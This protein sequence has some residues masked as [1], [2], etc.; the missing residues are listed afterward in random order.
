MHA[1]S[2]FRIGSFSCGL[3]SFVVPLELG[4]FRIILVVWG[5]FW[6]GGVWPGVEAN[7]QH[8][9][10][11]TGVSETSLPNT[12]QPTEIYQNSDVDMNR[13]KLL[14][15]FYVLLSSQDDTHKRLSK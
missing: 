9:H 1:P 5:V 7:I 2:P 12:W 14:H 15:R 11:E 4:Q 8:Q 10:P 13:T 3:C 6:G